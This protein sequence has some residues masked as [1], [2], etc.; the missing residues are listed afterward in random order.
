[1]FRMSGTTGHYGPMERLGCSHKGRI[2]VA[3][4]HPSVRLL[5]LG[6]EGMDSKYRPLGFVPRENLSS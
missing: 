3:L 6:P 2:S 5:T 4:F 1:M